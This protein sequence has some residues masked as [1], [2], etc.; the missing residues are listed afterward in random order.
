[1]PN[2]L[3]DDSNGEALDP[4]RLIKPGSQARVSISRQTGAEHVIILGV[5]VGGQVIELEMS[6]QSFAMAVTGRS[7]VP[8][9]VRRLFT[10]GGDPV[11]P[12]SSRCL[13]D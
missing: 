10:Q 8:T 9:V 11:T 4:R 12:Q 13:A 2:N 7:D 3:P 1:V 5:E 6:L